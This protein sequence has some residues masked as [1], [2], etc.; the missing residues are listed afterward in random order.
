AGR[1]VRE[2]LVR[3]LGRGFQ[4]RTNGSE[5]SDSQFR[6]GISAPD[7][8]FASSWFADWGG[9]FSAGRTVR[10][11]LIRRAINAGKRVRNED[12]GATTRGVLYTLA[13]KTE[14]HESVEVK[15]SPLETT[16]STENGSEIT[17]PESWI[18]H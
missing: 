4:R 3:R 5:S 17:G 6:K 1:T 10:N 9:V 2:Q 15:F 18:R 11:H 7:E 12:Q 14:V 8:R 13:A 16:K